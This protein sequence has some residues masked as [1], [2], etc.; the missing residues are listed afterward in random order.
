MNV[1]VRTDYALHAMV[2]L[3]ERDPELVKAEELAVSP[4][5]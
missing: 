2:M 1:S 4:V 5:T 3:A